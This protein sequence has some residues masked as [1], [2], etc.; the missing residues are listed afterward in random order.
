MC[1]WLMGVGRAADRPDRLGV[2]FAPAVSDEGEVGAWAFEQ[3]P[4][5]AGTGRGRELI[6]EVAARLPVIIAED[7][8]LAPGLT[9]SVLTLREPPTEAPRRERRRPLRALRA[10]RRHR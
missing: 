6:D 3:R 2:L 1:L 9:A 10:R 8:R 7:V 5:A 4:G